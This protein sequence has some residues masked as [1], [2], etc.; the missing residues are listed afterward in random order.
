MGVAPLRLLTSSVAVFLLLSLAFWFIFSQ[1]KFAWGWDAVYAYRQ[2]FIN[3][4]LMTVAHLGS[5]FVF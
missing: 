2:K 5:G 4:W 3:G 1:I